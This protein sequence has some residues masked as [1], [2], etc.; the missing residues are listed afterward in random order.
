MYR[1]FFALSSFGPAALLVLSILDVANSFSSNGIA[2]VRPPSRGLIESAFSQAYREINTSRQYADVIDRRPSVVEESKFEL[3]MRKL[4]ENQKELEAA[5]ATAPVKKTSANPIQEILTM[6]EYNSVVMEETEKMV[7][8]RFHAPWCRACKAMKPSFEKFAR[9][10]A[11]T[12]KFVECPLSAV[13]TEVHQGLGIKTIPFAHVYHPSAGLVEE[14]KMS[15]PHYASFE[16]LMK[17]Y[18][19]GECVIKTTEDEEF[20]LDPYPHIPR[21]EE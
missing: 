21:A 19:K 17:D 8:V 20:A 3:R 11:D 7:V 2:A 1:S 14:R 9:E 10:H 12:I 4:L 5:V 15:R 16:K 6:K 13:N 18:M